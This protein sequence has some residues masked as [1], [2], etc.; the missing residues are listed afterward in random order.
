VLLAIGL[1]S[2]TLIGF[3]TVLWAQLA[4]LVIAVCC[5][6]VREWRLDAH[7]KALSH[8]VEDAKEAAVDATTD[9]IVILGDSFEPIAEVLGRIAAAPSRR[10]RAELAQLL[11]QK[12]VDAAAKICGPQEAGEV[13][14]TYYQLNGSSLRFVAHGGRGDIPRH[15]YLPQD[16]VALARE[17]RNVLVPDVRT[18]TDDPDRFTDATYKTFL[19]CSVYAGTEVLG[20][21]TVDA[22]QPRSLNKTRDLR[23]A[24]VLAGMLGTGLCLAS[25]TSAKS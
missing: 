1:A 14:S 7:S 20:L 22:R 21:L 15:G 16:C 8:Q 5:A 25:A 17:R 10:E 23:S 12:V 19:A 24:L 4:L 11:T 6:V 2:A 3:V 9:L 13:R 18:D